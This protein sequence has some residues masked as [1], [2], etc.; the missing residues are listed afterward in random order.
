MSKKNYD[1]KGYKHSWEDKNQLHSVSFGKVKSRQFYVIE[2]Y[3]GE[4]TTT[5]GLTLKAT[6][7]LYDLMRRLLHE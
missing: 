1:I 2:L 7:A 5:V 3:N 4:K 6:A